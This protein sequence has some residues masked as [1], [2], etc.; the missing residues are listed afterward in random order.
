M[1]GEGKV[2][3]PHS[4]LFAHPGL[5]AQ[6]QLEAGQSREA[7]FW[8]WRRRADPRRAPTCVEKATSGPEVSMGAGES[9]GKGFRW[10]VGLKFKDM[11]NKGETLILMGNKR[12]TDSRRRTL[13]WWGT[14]C[15]GKT[16][17]KPKQKMS[18]SYKKPKTTTH[19]Q[20]LGQTA[21]QCGS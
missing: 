3:S 2:C 10:Q 11:D 9:A 8:L 21:Q 15:K 5:W 19:T 16:P 20:M 17:Q 13:K 18:Q 1:R 4:G 7:R 6:N 12:K 14:F